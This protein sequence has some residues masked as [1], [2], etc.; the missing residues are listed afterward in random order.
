MAG[1][2]RT[3]AR[4]TGSAHGTGRA[5]WSKT[6]AVAVCVCAVAG[7]DALGEDIAGG[8]VRVIPT[9]TRGVEQP[10]VSP[11]PISGG[12]LAISA[13]G[14][15]AIVADSERD[16]VTIV[17]LPSMEIVG[18]VAL[19]Q[20][21]EPGRLAI[22]G[23][24]IAHVALR[25]TGELVSVDA[26][27]ASVVRRDSVCGA[28]RGVAYDA[29]T[30][31]VHV[32][33]AGGELVALAAANGEEAWRTQVEVDLRDVLVSG[34]H[35]VVTRFKSAEQ[36][37]VDKLGH[38]MSRKR[39]SS[40]LHNTSLK[41]QVMD[42]AVAW[43]AVEGGNGDVVM[44]HQRA[45]REAVVIDQPVQQDSG[46]SSYGGGGG[47]DFFREPTCDSIVHTAVSV[48][49]ASGQEQVSLPLPD[50][51]LAVD[52]AASST[53]IAV[54]V[55]GHADPDAPRPF[56]HFEGD[57]DD[58]VSFGG[59]STF[60]PQTGSVLVVQRS[61]LSVVDAT[62]NE[63]FGCHSVGTIMPPSSDGVTPTA[64]QVT[65]VAFT[66][67]G[68]L[69]FLTRE[70]STLSF[71]STASSFGL[72]TSVTARVELGGESVADTGHDL[73]H[74]DS[75]G[76]IACASCHA[77][78]SDDGH[79]WDFNTIGLR[80]TQ[81]I[82]VGLEGTAPFHWDGDMSGLHEI[83]DTVF[84][85]RMGGV[86]QSA[87]RLGALQGWVFEQAPPAAVR[88][89]DDA[90]AA[91]GHALFNADEVGCATCHSGAKLTNNASVDV[92]TGEPG[93]RFQVP[94]LVGIAYRAPF[95]HTGCAS[96]LRDRFTNTEC[97]GGDQHGNTSHLSSEQIDDLVAY[98]ETL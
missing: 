80:R 10:L 89:A 58:G 77:E 3:S 33:C 37:H 92:G 67:N 55:A 40:L 29:A 64:E 12:T 14:T 65:A 8:D 11:P 21:D 52:V 73:F 95:M 32:A 91:R 54:A 35:L 87:D 46:G 41:S 31:R 45:Q 72:P 42:P 39:P 86:R 70:P 82:N 15:R 76:G 69:V 85:G 61:S 56:T 93:Q 30:D 48:S 47:N 66:P 6:W 34:D 19:E 24:N 44:V 38:V 7:C 18:R 94:S 59:G 68:D 78:S 13:D 75:G 2:L 97:A 71:V 62:N 4:S 90:A 23:N 74:R 36:L 81:S 60:G 27:T 17:S 49:S 88:G 51:V 25:G 98:L 9:D 96:T 84:I 5:P 28:P 16:V 57:G 63:S 79:T 26:A 1:S 83:M 53:L 43:R 22:D 50:T 20:G